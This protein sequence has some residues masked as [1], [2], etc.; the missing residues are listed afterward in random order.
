M[1]DFPHSGDIQSQPCK[2]GCLIEV[3]VVIV[4]WC[5]DGRADAHIGGFSTVGL[6]FRH[7]VGG[8]LGAGESGFSYIVG[9]GGDSGSTR[10]DEWFHFRVAVGAGCAAHDLC[11]HGTVEHLRSPLCGVMAFLRT[12]F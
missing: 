5:S 3:E 7:Q 4:V 11:I 6:D 2:Q 12:R 9:D 10:V 1:Q 8:V